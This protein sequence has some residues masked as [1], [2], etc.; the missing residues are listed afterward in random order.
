MNNRITSLVLFLFLSFSLQAK[1]LIFT[2]A[3]NRP[4]FIEYQYKTFNHFIRDEYE[5]VVFND[6]NNNDMAHRIEEMCRK[7]SIKHVR[8]P[9][10]IHDKPY[11]FRLPRESY[12]APAVRNA[13]VVMYSLDIMGFNHDDILVLLD[14]DI[15]ITKPVSF[16]NLLSD[17]DIFGLPQSKKDEHLVEYL[18][19]GFCCLNMKNLPN[20]HTL[21]FNCGEV[22]GLRVDAGGYTYYYLKNNPSVKVKW[23]NHFY[24]HLIAC[25]LCSSKGI[26]DCEHRIDMFYNC[27]FDLKKHQ[28]DFMVNIKDV[29]FFNDLTFLHYRCGSNWN[30]QTTEFIAKKTNEL[31]TFIQKL[32]DSDN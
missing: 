32:L 8:I 30:N 28:V 13:N 16:R 9:Q 31:N 27:K 4:D 10:Y 11:L 19:I 24:P 2:Y 12:H 15:F 7:Y 5:F 1:V 26:N 20:I 18:W 23:T 22:A 14:S 3:F 17:C 25:D 6:A 21:N 29:E